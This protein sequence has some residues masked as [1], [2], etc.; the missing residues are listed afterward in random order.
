MKK[1]TLIAIAAVFIIGTL[2][3]CNANVC[4]AYVMENPTIQVENNG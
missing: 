3:S 2:V 1:L 4:P